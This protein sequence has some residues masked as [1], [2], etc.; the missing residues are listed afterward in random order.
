LNTDNL[1]I[2]GES[3][4][5][6]PYR[7]LPHFDPGF[8]AAYFDHEGLYAYGRQPQAAYWNLH[9]LAFALSL[10]SGS[11]EAHQ[12]QAEDLFAKHLD[13]ELRFFILNRLNLKPRADKED[14]AWV[15]STF[16]F[17]RGSRAPFDAFFFDWQGGLESEAEALS[18][19][20][21]GHYRGAA[22]EDWK[23]RTQPYACAD[24]K[25]RQRLR[26]KWK[27]PES[28]LIDEVESIWAAVESGDWSP[29]EEKLASFR[30]WGRDHRE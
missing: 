6:G 20:R 5:Y 9:Q 27:N 28:L 26:Q 30:R 10:L 15:E 4:D 3:F 12:R 23:A 14:A 18:S 24:E 8:T 16:E 21:G 25:L 7:F 19:A 17:L 13:R 1:V 2:T 11:L 29:F 22:F